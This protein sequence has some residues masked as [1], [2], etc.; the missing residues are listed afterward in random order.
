VVGSSLVVTGE[1]GTIVQGVIDWVHPKLVSQNP[2]EKYFQ[3]KSWLGFG[4]SV[5]TVSR[6][7]YIF[8]IAFFMIALGLSIFVQIKKQHPHVIVQTMTLLGLLVCLYI[9]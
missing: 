6:W 8:F 9:I 5:F 2:I 3:A 4:F 7:I 1:D